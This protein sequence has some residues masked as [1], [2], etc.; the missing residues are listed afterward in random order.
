MSRLFRIIQAA[1]MLI[2]T[3]IPKSFI[4]VIITISICFSSEIVYGQTSAQKN[5]IV[6]MNYCVNSLTNIVNNHSMATLNYES[7]QILNNLK[8]ENIRGEY[9]LQE[10]RIALFDAINGL[11]ITEQE[12][13]I[14]KQVQDIKSK[15][16]MWKSLS[17]ALNPTMLITGGGKT[18]QQIAFQ[19][20]LTAAR[21]AVDYQSAKGDNEIEE[22]QAMWEIK[23]KELDE[24]SSLRS[25][26]LK[27]LFSLYDKY[28]YLG[29]WDRLTEETSNKF[30]E[31]ISEPNSTKRV[32]LLK[33]NE[34]L[35]KMIPDF[36][37]YLGM[38]YIGDD[39]NGRDANYKMSLPY[40]DKY[41]KEYAKT[42]IFR[43][44]QKSGIIALTKLTFDKTLSEAETETLINT[45]LRNLPDNGAALLQCALIYITRL[46]R[47]DE[48]FDLLRIGLDNRYSNKAEILSTITQYLDEIKK[49]PKIYKD[50]IA[51][52]NQSSSIEMNAF[53]PFILA[54]NK[55]N[56]VANVNKMF[57]INDEPSIKVK[58][59]R[60]CDFSGLASYSV[61]SSGTKTAIVQQDLIP[62]KSFTIEELKK[63]VPVFARRG[64]ENLIFCFFEPVIYGKRYSVKKGLDYNAITKGTFQGADVFT[65]DDN[66]CSKIVSFCEKNETGNLVKVNCKQTKV[67]EK[68]NDLQLSFLDQY[69][70]PNKTVTMVKSVVSSRRSEYMYD[71]EYKG[72]SPLCFVPVRF[73]KTEGKYLVLDFGDFS[74][75]VLTYKKESSDW[76]PFSIEQNGILRFYEPQVVLDPKRDGVMKKVWNS[77]SNTASDV[78]DKV[79]NGT[80]KTV[81]AIS[82]KASQ[83]GSW[84]KDKVNK[85]TVSDE[86]K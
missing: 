73:E 63:K 17:S 38:A 28:H 25:K 35:F 40:L 21:T 22:I 85:G 16:L 55:G 67:K 86:K 5:V 53:V 80:S 13:A 8:I 64:N 70:I 57:Q 75:T 59:R 66:D 31:I 69:Y 81:D 46:E 20:I 1:N 82:N 6:Q 84:A 42:P 83:V 4:L 78:A 3:L 14:L 18:G 48:G 12:K 36:Y 54:N 34:K 62:E 56:W 71:V 37:Y 10:F 50:V 39:I 58:S 47:K 60:K 23:K 9:E 29:E 65:I 7:D 74:H 30:N 43:Y 11:Q 68:V 27:I 44:D 15:N 19:A 49:Y 61:E 51:A 32:R 77:V 45:A 33:E 52:V 2:H 79:K 41:L 24:I 72:E 26:A 76:I